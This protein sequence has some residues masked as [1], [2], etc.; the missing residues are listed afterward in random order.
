MPKQV[1]HDI[2][3]EKTMEPEIIFEDDNLIVI[4]KPAGMVVHQGAGEIGETTAD[5]LIRKYPEMKE[6]FGDDMRPGIVH[7]LDKMTSGI[8]VCAKDPMTR[9]KLQAQF[10]N[11]EVIKKYKTLVLGEMKPDHAVIESYISRDP[12]NR[13]IMKVQSIAF[14]QGE[15]VIRN[16]ITEY[17]TIKT[18]DYKLKK[19]PYLLSLLDIDLKTGRMHQIRAQMK[20]EGHPVIGDPDYFIKPSRKISQELGLERQFL[21][22]YHIEFTHPETGEKLVLEADLPEDLKSVLEKISK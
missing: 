2:F 9:A 14:A 22:S 20:Y 10:K 16:A 21:H 12:R 7:R 13:Q 11:R 18:F 5:W 8:L 19:Q 3:N 1:R 15:Q 6:R 4:N 17:K